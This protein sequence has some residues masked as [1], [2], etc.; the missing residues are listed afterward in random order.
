MESEMYAGQAPMLSGVARDPTFVSPKAAYNEAQQP[1]GGPPITQITLAHIGS[2][3]SQLSEIV[4]RLSDVRDRLFGS[5][6]TSL[7]RGDTPPS[8]PI[9]NFS[10]AFARSAQETHL[11]L[12]QLD[13]L[14]VELSNRL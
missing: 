11:L 3:N 7:G 14:S 5:Q 2:T 13:R 8:P 10:E 6:P 1:G 9:S 4:G 12:A